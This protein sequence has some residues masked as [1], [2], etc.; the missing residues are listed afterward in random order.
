MSDKPKPNID[1]LVSLTLPEEERLKK[2]DRIVNGPSEELKASQAKASRNGDLTF[3][4]WDYRAAVIKRSTH[5][6]YAFLPQYQEWRPVDFADVFHTAAVM[7][8]DEFLEL[9]PEVDLETIPWKEV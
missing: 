9:F 8:I 3:T 5:E 7:W 4:N 2:Y 6:A 1:D